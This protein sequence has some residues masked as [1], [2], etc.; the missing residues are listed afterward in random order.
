MTRLA[1]F[2]RDGRGVAAV[3]F[4]LIA[5]ILLVMY[6]LTMET[7][8]AIETSKKVGRLGSM[9]ADLVTQQQSVT[10]S[11]LDAIMQIGQTTLLPY[12]RSQPTITITGITITTDPTPKIQVAWSRKLTNGVSGAGAAKNSTTTVP[13]SLIIPGTFLVRVES[14]L[15][16]KPVIAWSA[17]GKSALG[18]AA[19]FDSINMGDT[20]YL[21][22]RISATIPCTDC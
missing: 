8:Q 13:A 12:G 1:A 5:P 2:G 7:S 6:F 4:A 15:G 10:K 16:Y 3:E 19:A 11:A 20:Y 22:P 18:L 21:R 14:D 9:V 17:S